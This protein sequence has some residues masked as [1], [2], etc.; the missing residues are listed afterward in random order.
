MLQE[1]EI[2]TKVVETFEAEGSHPLKVQK[3]WLQPILKVLKNT[4]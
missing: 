4:Q 3:S 2:E 1:R